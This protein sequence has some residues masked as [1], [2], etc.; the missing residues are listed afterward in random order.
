MSRKREKRGLSPDTAASDPPT[1]RKKTQESVYT[2]GPYSSGR[3]D[4]TE[5]VRAMMGDFFCSI[6]NIVNN[7]N[8][9][10][11]TIVKVYKRF[12][13]ISKNLGGKW[14]RPM[15]V[16]PRSEMLQDEWEEQK[17][18]EREAHAKFLEVLELELELATSEAPDTPK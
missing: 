11:R 6:R 4:A 17:K 3:S 18:L 14:E 5:E 1:K 12:A 8:L 9:R 13:S 16:A 15:A 7:Y 2:S 10:V